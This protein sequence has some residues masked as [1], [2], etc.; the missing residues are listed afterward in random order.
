MQVQNFE[1]KLINL[2]KK[3]KLWDK[4]ITNEIANENKINTIN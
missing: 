4:V 1:R 2:W 3:Q